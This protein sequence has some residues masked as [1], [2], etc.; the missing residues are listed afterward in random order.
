MKHIVGRGQV[1]KTLRSTT[2]HQFTLLPITSASGE[3]IICVIIFQGKSS[4]IP[5]HW[6]S[7]IDTWVDPVR[8]SDGGIRVDGE[9]NFGKDK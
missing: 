4:E 2:N 3:P 7:G 6:V 1:P 9:F 5:S 8:G